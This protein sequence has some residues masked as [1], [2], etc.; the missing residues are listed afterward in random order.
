MI[1][2]IYFSLFV[3]CFVAFSVSS[4]YAQEKLPNIVIILADD[5]G[6]GSTGIYGANTSVL[7]TPAIDK[8]AKDGRK[9][10]NAYT[11]SSV[12][13]P[14]RYGL[15]TGQYQWQEG[16]RYGVSGV[17]SALTLNLERPTIASRLKALG[18]NTAAIGKWHL[19]YQSK[20]P[21]D[22]TKPLTPGPLDLG[23]DYHWGVPSN[24]GDISGI[25][26][27][28]NHTYGLVDSMDDLPPQQRQPKVNWKGK[29]MIG[30]PAPYR[31]NTE[32]TSILNRRIDEWIDSQS[33]DKPF[34]LYYPMPAI[35]APIT[36]SQPFVGASNGG[37]YSDYIMELDASV[38]SVLDA[39]ERNNFTDDTIVIFTSDNGGHPAGAKDAIDAGLKIN[40]D[41]R[42]TKLTVF[43]GGFRVPFIVKWPDRIKTGSTSKELVNL[44]DIY[45]TVLDVVNQDMQDPLDEAGDSYSFYPA[46]FGA[47]EK[48]IRDN[49]IY[50]SFEGIVA[51]QVGDWKYIE[52]IIADPNPPFIKGNNHPRRLAEA[53]EQL[54]NLKVDPN[55]TNDLIDVNV[56]KVKEMKQLLKKIRSQKYSRQ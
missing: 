24:N 53:H 44:V 5:L 25:W 6:Y 38:G 42:G 4:G 54:Y 40:G 33:A 36:P 2:N 32:T 49:M 37:V 18:Y 28:N 16:K 47:P 39:L 3:F 17:K 34:F 7:E 22:Y 35:H 41:F 48:P 13:S 55:E 8:L 29:P 43:D 31:A 27:E 15:L 19:G 56:E 46:L 52:G 12:C 50:T 30:I 10:M 1:K 45:A 9:F 14:T 21:T 26:V 23:F 20:N 51:F 11:P